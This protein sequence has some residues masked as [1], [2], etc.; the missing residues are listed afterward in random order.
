MSQGGTALLGLAALVAATH[1]LRVRVVAHVDMRLV[2]ACA[3]PQVQ[4]LRRNSMRIYLAS[5]AVAACVVFAEAV[6]ILG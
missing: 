2:P 3:R 6:V 4:R 1:W 5:A